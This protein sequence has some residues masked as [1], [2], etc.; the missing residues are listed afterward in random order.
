MATTNPLSQLLHE[1]RRVNAEW[2]WPVATAGEVVGVLEELGLLI[3]GVELWQFGEG[4][5]P[6]VKGWSE[7]ELPVGDWAEVVAGT[8]SLAR[9]AFFEHIGNLDLWVNLSW[10]SEEELVSR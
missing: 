6:T 8:A 1:A 5:A 9:A 10:A 4:D 3:L 7:Y 2:C